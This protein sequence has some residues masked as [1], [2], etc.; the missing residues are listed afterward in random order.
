MDGGVL[1]EASS[2]AMKCWHWISLTAVAWA[3]VACAGRR[4]GGE[5]APVAST[6]GAA[7]TDWTARVAM[8]LKVKGSPANTTRPCMANSP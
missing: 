8:A 1:R 7:R 2:P 4:G 5:G 3:M 6:G